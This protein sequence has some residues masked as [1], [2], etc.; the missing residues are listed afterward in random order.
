MT[1]ATLRRNRRHFGDA[2]EDPEGS[3]PGRAVYNSDGAEY[4]ELLPDDAYPRQFRLRTFTSSGRFMVNEP[5]YIAKVAEAQQASKATV[6]VQDDNE[7]NLFP[8]TSSLH[9]KKT[10]PP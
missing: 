5:E 7:H 6:E 1:N 4:P 9:K 10:E 2:Y 3:R 8:D